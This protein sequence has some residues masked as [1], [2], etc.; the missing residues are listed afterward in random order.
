MAVPNAVTQVDY[1]VRADG[2]AFCRYELAGFREPGDW[3]GWARDVTVATMQDEWISYCDAAR[4]QYRFAR[5]AGGRLVACLF[6]SADH[7]L[8]SRAWLSGLFS[9]TSLSVEARRD[10]LAGR[11]VSGQDDAG[12]TICSCFGVGQFSIEKAIGERDLTTAQAVGECLQAGTNCG[13]CI[14]EINALIKSARQSS[15]DQQAAEN[16]A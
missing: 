10:L 6:V 14:P 13:S 2:P 12:P 5:V 7:H 9:Q 8:P 16:V 15:Q 3:E 1:W 11:P 4:K